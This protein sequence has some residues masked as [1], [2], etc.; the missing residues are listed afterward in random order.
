MSEP[1]WQAMSA[2][3]LLAAAKQAG[4]Q[5]W[6]DGDRLVVRGPRTGEEL[7]RQLLERKQQVLGELR[8]PLRPTA[9]GAMSPPM[10]VSSLSHAAVYAM[11]NV[12]AEGEGEPATRWDVHA[13]AVVSAVDAMVEAALASSPLSG[14]RARQNV[15]RNECGIVRRLAREGDPFLRE[16]PEALRVLLARWATWDGAR[17]S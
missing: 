14:D 2:G 15:L 17:S 12:D 5:V 11:G 10:P 8:S 4:L 1:S 13:A 7:G 3:E 9:P 16:W 6:V